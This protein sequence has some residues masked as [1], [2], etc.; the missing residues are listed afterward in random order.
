MKRTRTASQLLLILLCSLGV[1]A[2]GGYILNLQPFHNMTGFVAT[3][4]TARK[5]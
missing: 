3:Y 2:A 4:N 1:V 5:H